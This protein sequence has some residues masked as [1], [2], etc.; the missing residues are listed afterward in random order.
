MA[1]THTDIRTNTWDHCPAPQVILGTFIDA[2]IS[3]LKRILI[4]SVIQCFSMHH[5]SALYPDWTPGVM[6]IIHTPRG[7]CPAAC[8]ALD[9]SSAVRVQLRDPLYRVKARCN[10][11]WRLSG[12]A[13]FTRP[14]LLTQE[15]WKRLMYSGQRA[16]A[17]RRDK[18]VMVGRYING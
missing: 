5:V 12:S 13:A 1:T 8:N 7:L 6:C 2:G 16:S 17:Q 14:G 9:I 4:C 11:D 3:T 18:H 15:M 10:E